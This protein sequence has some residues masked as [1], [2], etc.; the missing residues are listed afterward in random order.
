MSNT[1]NERLEQL[2]KM[3]I[4]D[5]KTNTHYKCN[6]KSCTFT[7][8]ASETFSHHDEESHK[9]KDFSHS[10]FTIYR[11]GKNTHIALGFA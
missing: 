6:A 10:D 11:N 9:K 1:K 3:D 7:G 2:K 4:M 5:K 8:N